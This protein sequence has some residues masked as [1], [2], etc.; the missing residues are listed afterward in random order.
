MPAN[1]G[2]DGIRA[3]SR[4]FLGAFSAEFSLDPAEVVQTGPDWVIERG[5][6]EIAL[7]PQGGGGGPLRDRGKYVT[8]YQRQGQHW[9][10]A[11]DIWNSDL[12]LPPQP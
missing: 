1:L 12:P 3:W 8:V 7:T 4:G 6:Y 10:M 11:R 5:A 2:I 9:K